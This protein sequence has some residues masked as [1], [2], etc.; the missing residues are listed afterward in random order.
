MWEEV[1]GAAGLDRGGRLVAAGP[2]RWRCS[3]GRYVFPAPGTRVRKRLHSTASR[4]CKKN[5]DHAM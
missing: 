5:A 2:T 1:I 4:G 3:C